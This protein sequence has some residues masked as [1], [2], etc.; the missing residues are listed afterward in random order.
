ML[1]LWFEPDNILAIAHIERIPFMGDHKKIPRAAVA[2]V[3]CA[4]ALRMAAGLGQDLWDDEVA[5]LI[6]ATTSI[7]SLK[8]YFLTDPHPPLFFLIL[9]PWALVSK[10]TIWLRLLPEIF[11]AATVAVLF[12]WIYRVSGRKAAFWAALLLTFAP[13]HVW[14]STELRSH[15]LVAFFVVSGLAL[16]NNYLETEKNRKLLFAGALCLLFAAWSHYY[17]LI[18]A[19]AF[20]AGLI[21]VSQNRKRSA[22][23]FIGIFAVGWLPWTPFLVSQISSMQAF[24]TITPL[25][26]WMFSMGV[27]LGFASFPWS[28]P[29]LLIFEKM[30]QNAWIPYLSW[31]SLFGAIFWLPVFGAWPKKLRFAGLSTALTVLFVLIG[32]RFVPGFEVRYMNFLIPLILAI[33]AVL[34]QERHPKLGAVLMSVLLIAFCLSDTEALIR[35]KNQRP[36]FS[37][38][39]DFV[40][41]ENGVALIYNEAAAPG[42]IRTAKGKVKTI[43]LRGGLDEKGQTSGSFIKKLSKGNGPYFQIIANENLWDPDR[44]IENAL[45]DRLG[46]PSCSQM[47]SAMRIIVC[48]YHPLKVYD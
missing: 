41:K 11:G 18:A 10:S 40:Q 4:F 38:L 9:K 39:V 46:T 7:K 28:L 29:T 27:M 24:R 3:A 15:S 8:G 48:S 30:A 23:S 36:D 13:F 45:K 6:V 35:E 42:F 22:V 16:L 21:V 32:S 37:V 5:S 12:G 34:Y 25:A 20:G 31:M 19:L 43:A 26:D 44:Q 2:L 33:G 47:K 1:Y 14:A 17:G